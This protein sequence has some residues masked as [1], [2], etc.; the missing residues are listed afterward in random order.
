MVA[1]VTVQS[2]RLEASLT[3]ALKDYP[4]A[5][6]RALSITV[7]QCRNEAR[8]NFSRDIKNGASR[9]TISNISMKFPNVAKVRRNDATAFVFIRQPLLD[10]IHPQV[11]GGRVTQTAG[12]AS[13]SKGRD[14]F[15]ITPVRLAVNKLG[16]ISSLRKKLA[17]MRADKTNFLE[18][19]L[20]NRDKATAHLEAGMYKRK[21]QRRRR[22]R[23]PTTGR[24]RSRRA[25]KPASLIMILAYSTERDYKAALSY[26]EPLIRC[27]ERWFPGL[28]AVAMR[29]WGRN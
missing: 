24:R 22:S 21:R 3:R 10:A 8:R 25:R 23:T 16:N 11:F 12:T 7:K 20:F 5:L 15:V 28:L 6:S 13:V 4:F 18:V 19:P 2:A 14:G 26:H 1:R 27:Y 17:K 9:S 29:K